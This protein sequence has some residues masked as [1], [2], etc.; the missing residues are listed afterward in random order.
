M[1]PR[2]ATDFAWSTVSKWIPLI[3]L[4]VPADDPA[5]TGSLLNCTLNWLG[6]MEEGR[7]IEAIKRLRAA[8]FAPECQ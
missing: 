5:A 4:K 3:L 1:A 8:T 2:I 7:T 6:L